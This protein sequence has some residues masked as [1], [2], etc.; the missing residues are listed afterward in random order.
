ML[1]FRIISGNLKTRMRA[2]KILHLAALLISPLAA[3]QI[4]HGQSA[5]V[6]LT[7]GDRTKLMQPQASVAF[8]PGAPAGNFVTVDDGQIFQEIE[9]F[10][11]AF[12]DSTGYVLNQM[13]SAQARTNVMR[14]LF[15]R[16]GNGIGLGFMRVPMGGSDL[17]RFHYSYDDR[18]AGQTDTNLAY[19]T[20]AHDLVDIIPLIRQAR[21]LNPKMRLMA[22]PWSPPGWMKSSDSLIGGTLLP[23]MYGPYASYFVK[24]I[25]AYEAQGIPIDYLSLQNEPLY[26]PGDYPGMD[27]SASVQTLVLRDHVLPALAAHQITTKVLIYDHNWDRGDYPETILADAAL[28][29]SPQ[30]AGTAWHGY[31]GTPGAM[32]AVAGKYPGKG[33][34]QTEHS[35]GD[36]VGDQVRTDFTEI[37]HTLRSSTRCFVK[38]NLCGD[39]NKGPH[40]GGCGT[41][42]PLVTINSNTGQ[43]SYTIDFYTLGHFSKFILPG[44]RRIQ[45]SNAS[46]VL[47][48]A[49]LNPDGTRVL[50]AFNDT[51]ASNPFQVRWGSKAFSYTLPANSGATFVWAGSASD[52]TRLP[53][54]SQIFASSF[55]GVSG[56]QTETCSDDTGGL[57]LGFAESGDYAFYRNVEFPAGIQKV[58][59]RAASASSGGTIELRLDSATGP[60]ASTI[61]IPATG[62]WQTWQTVTGSVSSVS[63]V[64]NLHVVFKGGSGIGNLNWFQFLTAAPSLPQP[65]KSADVGAVGF[66]GSASHQD[67]VFTILASGED[68]WEGADAFHF[69]QQPSR[70]ASELRARVT[71]LQD[72][73]AWA[74]AGVMIREGAAPGAMNA[75][76]VVTPANGVAFQVRN[77]NGAAATSVIV[78]GVTVPCWVRLVRTERN[79]ISGYYSPDGTN[80]VQVGSRIGL[81][82]STNAVAGL[83]ASAQ[84]NAVLGMATFDHVAIRHATRL[85]AALI[86]GQCGFWIEG[87]AGP[88]FTITASTNLITWSAIATAAPPALPWFWVDTNTAAHPARYYRVV[89]GP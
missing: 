29:S 60:L 25:Q 43:T 14:S 64:H 13:A 79:V 36:W 44:A 27:M 87:E 16:E 28:R 48:A 10:G 19:F 61:A 8:I 58:V 23:S 80:W 88:D 51:S 67:G 53:A 59:A 76:V 17:A 2:L 75:A 32:L 42:T 81:P 71:G 57:N 69:V 37:I 47:S 20:I 40:A 73:H 41:C 86:S 72:T 62:G 56:L 45:S 50:I 55:S 22:S 30:I 35:D 18:P 12:T 52:Q 24:F 85:T 78:P 77:S 4:L 38:W 66:S 6:W 68:I 82:F 1:V 34:Y 65:W 33:N 21:Q 54:T 89:P 26:V 46:G 70:P 9:G 11:A 84:N 74:K 49:F 7:T 15:S 63:G 5:A 83:A 3:P 39:Q 31:G